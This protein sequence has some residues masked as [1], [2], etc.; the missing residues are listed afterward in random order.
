[1]VGGQAGLSGVGCEAVEQLLEDGGA[2]LAGGCRVLGVQ[3][4]VAS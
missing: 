1:L 3:A 4:F 2:F